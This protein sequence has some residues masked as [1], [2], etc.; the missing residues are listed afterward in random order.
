MMKL[1]GGKRSEMTARKRDGNLSVICIEERGGAPV[2][3]LVP[4]ADLVRRAGLK[5]AADGPRGKGSPDC[6]IEWKASRNHLGVSITK[7]GRTLPLPLQPVHKK[8]LLAVCIHSD[9]GET[10]AP[11]EIAQMRGPQAAVPAVYARVSEIRRAVSRLR[12]GVDGKEVVALSDGA[13]RIGPSVAVELPSSLANA[14]ADFY[15]CYLRGS[16]LRDRFGNR[17]EIRERFEAFARDRGLG[18]LLDA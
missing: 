3:R 17:P 14:Q 10:L 8:I 6:V 11:Q 2:P 18:N 13:Y 5:P 16:S 9:L 15:F 1:D 12:L 4:L 7:K